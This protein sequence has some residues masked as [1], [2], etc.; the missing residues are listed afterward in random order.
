MNES[1]K[2]IVITNY[3]I[4]KYLI[5]DKNLLVNKDVIIESKKFVNFKRNYL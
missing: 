4:N 1:I 5:E 3:K 2:D